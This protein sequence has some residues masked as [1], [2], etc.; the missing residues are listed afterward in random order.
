MADIWRVV[1]EGDPV[2]TVPH[3]LALGKLYCCSRIYKHVHSEVMLKKCGQLVA[4][5]GYLDHALEGT[6]PLNHSMDLYLARLEYRMRTR[7]KWLWSKARVCVRTM[8]RLTF[9]LRAARIRQ[10]SDGDACISMH[11]PKADEA[12]KVL[13]DSMQDSRL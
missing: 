11:D 2:P 3:V 10:S 12:V 4:S 9:S 1:N 13:V 5:P 8:A 6:N 7:N